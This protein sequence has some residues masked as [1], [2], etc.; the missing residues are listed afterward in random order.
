MERRAVDDQESSPRPDG[1]GG[2]LTA[3]ATV[4]EHG[5]VTG[6]NAGAER[7]LGYSAAQILGRAA[8]SLLAEDPGTGDLPP[9]PPFSEL[10]ELPRWNGTLAL[11]HLDGHR[12]EARV[13]AHHRTPGRTEEGAPGGGMCGWVLVS[14][15]PGR[16]RPG[17]TTTRS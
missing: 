6:W 15:V 16:R 5:I 9:L 8:A 7:L 3:R 10:P 1:A 13:L 4:D 12:V 14:A 17:P 2:A 11:R